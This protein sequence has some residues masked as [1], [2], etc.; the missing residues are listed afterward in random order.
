M[1]T[2]IRLSL[3]GQPFN[4]T[5]IPHLESQDIKR[6][7]QAYLERSEG[8]KDMQELRINLWRA[9]HTT[10]GYLYC[11]VG[12]FTGSESCFVEVHRQFNGANDHDDEPPRLRV[13]KWETVSFL[14]I[15]EYHFSTFGVSV[16]HGHCMTE[17]EC[18]TIKAGLGFTPSEDQTLVGKKKVVAIGGTFYELTPIS[19]TK[20]SLAQ[21][22]G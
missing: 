6:A 13:T 20:P 12:T 1:P 22:N 21:P 5:D 11:G 10:E 7:L 8:F 17:A 2:S 19:L 16:I 14:E 4:Q 9:E 3:C 15:L 18:E